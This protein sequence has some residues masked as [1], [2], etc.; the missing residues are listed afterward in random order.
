MTSSHLNAQVS[1]EIPV[2]K[3]LTELWWGPQVARPHVCATAGSDGEAQRLLPTVS[4]GLRHMNSG[5]S[6]EVRNQ[7]VWARLLPSDYLVLC[8]PLPLAQVS[9]ACL[10]MTMG[11]HSH[12]MRSGHG[13]ISFLEAS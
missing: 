12:T 4:A 9:W 10:G 7:P 13:Y 3:S 6:W 5:P 1:A 2:E 8:L 11:M